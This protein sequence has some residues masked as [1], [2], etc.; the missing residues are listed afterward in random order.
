VYFRTVIIRG[1]SVQV[2]F[3]EVKILHDGAFPPYVCVP[4]FGSAHRL[5]CAAHKSL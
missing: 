3:T 2:D 1:F 5:I 4:F